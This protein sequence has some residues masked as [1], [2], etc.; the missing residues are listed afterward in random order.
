MK[1]SSKIEN[2]GFNSLNMKTFST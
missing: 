1:D 2:L